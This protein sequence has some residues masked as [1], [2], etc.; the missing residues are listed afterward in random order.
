[1][2]R[3]A[4]RIV[5]LKARRNGNKKGVKAVDK[6]MRD[7][8]LMSVFNDYLSEEFYG[9][10]LGLLD[11]LKDNWEII[12]EAILKIISLFTEED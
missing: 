10:S 5:R 8:E 7:R 6:L 11:W 9:S 4:L 3:L 2:S 1:M 12:L